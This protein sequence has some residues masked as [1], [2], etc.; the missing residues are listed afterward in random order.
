MREIFFMRMSHGKIA[1]MT[2]TWNPDD[3]RQQLGIP[4]A[5]MSAEHTG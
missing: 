3:L 2:A 1:E 4:L 5:R